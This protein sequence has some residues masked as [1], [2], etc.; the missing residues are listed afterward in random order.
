MLEGRE[1]DIKDSQNY[2]IIGRA[3]VFVLGDIDGYNK[4]LKITFAF[5]DNDK[6]QDAYRYIIDNL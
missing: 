6:I 5:L 1:Y 2:D 4:D 3:I